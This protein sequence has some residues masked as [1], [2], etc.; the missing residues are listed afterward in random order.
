MNRKIQLFRLMTYAGFLLATSAVWMFTGQVEASI[1]ND[2]IEVQNNPH[3]LPNELNPKFPHIYEKLEVIKTKTVELMV[4]STE[5]FHSLALSGRKIKDI[6]T[7]DY[8]TG[9]SN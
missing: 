1:L 6:P 5:T 9:T 3:H 4:E 8:T 7:Y 2:S